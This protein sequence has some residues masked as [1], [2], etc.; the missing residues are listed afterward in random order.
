M[1]EPATPPFDYQA[2]DSKTRQFVQQK[3]N[4]THGLLKRTAEHILQIGQNLRVVKEKLPHGQF[5][6][7]IETEFEMSRWTARSF[8]RVANKLEDKWR[9][10]H[11]LP[12]SVLYELAAPS[13][14]EDILTQVQ[15]GHIPPTIEAVRAAKEAERL[16]RATEQQAR[17][18]VEQAQ[19]RIST[20]QEETQVQQA[21][22]DKLTHDIKLLQERITTLSSPAVEIKEVEKF[23]VP[24]EIQTQIETLQQQLRAL[25]QQRDTLARQV[26]Q[27]GEEAQAAALKRGEGEQE[28]RIRLN[29]YRLTGEFHSTVVKLLSQWPSSLDTLAFEAD[30]WT[31]LVR[32]K[33]L[34]QR[35]LEACTALTQSK[36]VESATEETTERT[37]RNEYSNPAI[38]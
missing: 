19:R 24:P 1:S 7:W 9:N 27:L 2:L 5:L 36:I 33:E 15:E 12:V 31:R 18:E 17:A 6:L 23:V 21:T 14:S 34:A 4:E 13:I 28:R 35:F 16:A 26:K 32:T 38:R 25:T 10:F 11:H 8:I 30:D 20:M 3:A 29:W 22:I 37:T